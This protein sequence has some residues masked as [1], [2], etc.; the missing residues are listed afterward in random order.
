MAVVLSS[1]LG[2][3]FSCTFHCLNVSMWNWTRQA[4]ASSVNRHSATATICLMR[5]CNVRGPTIE[6]DREQLF[7]FVW[8]RGA[9]VTFSL[10]RT[11]YKFS[12]IHT[13]ITTTTAM[14]LHTL[15]E[16]PRST[17]PSILCGTVISFC[18]TTNK[19][20]KWNHV[21]DISLQ[22]GSQHSYSE[23]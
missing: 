4:S 10:R 12:D 22:A 3:F 8:D 6:C 13:Y 15:T 16:V 1:S 18:L 17:H 14:H 19:L 20:W 23:V 21:D 7:L 9:T 5:V 2:T 11:G